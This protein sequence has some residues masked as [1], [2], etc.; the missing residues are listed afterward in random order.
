[1][2]IDFTTDLMER[3]A[4]TAGA[5]FKVKVGSSISQ[6][7]VQMYKGG[8]ICCSYILFL[9]YPHENEIIWPQRTPPT[10][11]GSATA[12]SSIGGYTKRISIDV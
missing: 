2:L 6:N 11:S 4:T 12:D 8:L 3:H 9:K 1:M 5:Y 10:P 7:G